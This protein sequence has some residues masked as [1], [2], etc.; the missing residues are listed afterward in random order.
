MLHYKSKVGLAA[1]PHLFVK[2]GSERRFPLHNL[3]DTYLAH[4]VAQ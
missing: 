4:C 1:A 3:G 2:V